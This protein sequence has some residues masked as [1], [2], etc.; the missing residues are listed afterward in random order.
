MQFPRFMYN[1]KEQAVRVEDETKVDGLFVKPPHKWS[2]N[3][4]PLKYEVPKEEK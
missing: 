4:K 2:K 3:E 1:D